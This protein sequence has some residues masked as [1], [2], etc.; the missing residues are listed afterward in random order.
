M[1]CSA[2]SNSR[3]SVS[4]LSIALTWLCRLIVGT[5]FALGGWAKCVDPYGTLYKMLEYLG[6]FGMHSI[7]HEPVVMAA[8]ALGTL[9]FTIGI[10]CLLGVL[11]HSA[12]IL[13][14]AV[15]CFMLPLSFYIWTA[16]PVADCGCFG[17][18]LVISNFATF[19]K[20]IVLMAACLWLLRHNNDCPG[21]F[22]RSTHWIVVG[23]TIVYALVLAAIG[24]NVQP[25]ADFRSYPLGTSMCATTESPLELIYEKDGERQIF[26]E[27]DLPDST[28]TYL[29]LADIPNERAP[30]PVFDENGDEADIWEPEGK[31]LVIVVADPGEHFLTRSRFANDLARYAMQRGISVCAIIGTTSTGL[32]EW[33]LLAAPVFD[34]YSADDTD[35]KALVRGDIAAIYLN[36]GRIEWKRNLASLP[37]EMAD[38][39]DSEKNELDWISRPDDGSLALSLTSLYLT[40]LLLLALFGL[41]R[42]PVQKCSISSK[43][44]RLSAA[45]ETTK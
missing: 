34:T 20:N 7:H 41:F 1:R 11:R 18:I 26:A 16:N 6:A 15:M 19:I 10:C 42:R 44:T 35:L 25:V 29:G 22:A 32:H 21:L 17:D 2:S 14:T 31:Q 9:E 38:G 39:S 40:I 3:N 28:W 13:A 24:Y 5:A 43:Q 12:A 27:S 8:V 45:P 36:D 37:A 30:F 23:L 33:Q 4:D